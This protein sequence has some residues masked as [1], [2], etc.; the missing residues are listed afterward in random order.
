[1]ATQRLQVSRAI[2]VIPSNSVD[3]PNPAG[4]RIS[5]TNTSTSSSKLIDSAATFITSQVQVGDIVYNTTD[6]TCAT[7]TSIDSQTQLTL[8]ANIFGSTSRAYS[9]YDKT[10]NQ[11]GCVFFTGGAGDVS[12]ITEGGDS[13]TFAGA[14]AGQYH[15]VQVTRIL[16]TSTATLINAIW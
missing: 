3:I 4:L 7:V 14:V 1:M 6:S 5:S 13:V 9:L 8:S 2:R 12:V 11:G 15:P 16:A 10:A